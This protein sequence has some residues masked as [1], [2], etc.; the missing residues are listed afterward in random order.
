MNST[1]LAVILTLAGVVS[2]AGCSAAL[3]TPTASSTPSAAT[4]GPQASPESTP[5]S[6]TVPLTVG[7]IIDVR[8]PAEYAQGHLDGAVNIDVQSAD[9]ADRI[10]ELPADGQ[11]TVYC[12][13]GSRAGAA[14]T[15]MTALGFTDVTNAGSLAEASASTGVAVVTD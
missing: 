7:T 5:D 13:T 4:A 15:K 6:T 2:L 1:R 10:A 12:R 3:P 9:F 11:Y 8:T 14:V